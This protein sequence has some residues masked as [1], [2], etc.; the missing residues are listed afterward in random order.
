MTLFQ[1]RFVQ[2][3]TLIGCSLRA[4]AGNYYTRYNFDGTQKVTQNDYNG[5]DGNQLDGMYLRE[6]AIKI[7][8]QKGID[9]VISIMCSNIGYDD[10]SYKKWRRCS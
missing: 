3:L 4:T 6:E 8:T 2:Y 10:D 1:A 7:L 5:V 9:P